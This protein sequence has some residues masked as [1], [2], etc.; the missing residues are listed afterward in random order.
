MTWGV[1][2]TYSYDSAI[3]EN[4]G[5]SYNDGPPA[6]TGTHSWVPHRPGGGPLSG[7][8]PCRGPSS[9]GGRIENRPYANRS[10]HKNRTPAPPPSPC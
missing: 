1:T 6:V 7:L 2:V 9:R 5:I 4:T 10:W 3:G 8:V